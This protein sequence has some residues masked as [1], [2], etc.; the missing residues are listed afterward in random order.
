MTLHGGYDVFLRS[1][2]DVEPRLLGLR[3]A[4]AFPAF[5]A[6]HDASTFSPIEKG[7]YKPCDE[8]A[9]L[10]SYRAVC[11]ELFFFEGKA[12][13]DSLRDLDRGLPPDGQR[14]VQELAA[15]KAE[16][17]RLGLISLHQF[18]SAYDAALTTEDYSRMNFYAVE[19]ERPPDVMMAS[20]FAPFVDFR[21]KR[22]RHKDVLGTTDDHIVLSLFASGSVG[23]F[24]LAWL[25]DSQAGLAFTRSF[26]ELTESEMPHAVL[27]LVFSCF[28]NVFFLPSWWARLS[29]S[30]QTY[31]HRR[32]WKKENP[33]Q[34]EREDYLTDDGRR[35]VNWQ[36]T[37]TWGNVPLKPEQQQR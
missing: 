31:L 35:L 36:V 16:E 30:D 3:K 21:G 26:A 10:T 32:F 6:H 27:R 7:Q 12:K 13:L 18:K 1:E 22:I 19:F 15:S 34:P 5:C 4:S 37:T 2:G 17:D 11:R 20:M 25:G 23:W 28:E 24:Q 8:H 29:E 33:L 14:F 9:F